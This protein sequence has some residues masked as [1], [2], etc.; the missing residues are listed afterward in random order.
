MQD[1]TT[2]CTVACTASTLQLW[3]A[4]FFGALIGWYV[5]FINRYRASEVQ[6]SDLVTLLGV[7]GGG[8]VLT[9]FP[10]RSDLFGAYGIGLFAGFFLYF[11]LLVVMVGKS[12]NFTL[13]W[14]LDGRRKKVADDEMIGP[15]TRPTMGAMLAKGPGPQ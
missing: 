3:G 9:L 6:I 14:F 15:E 12:P 5:Y 8:A 4:A 1:S 2:V 10:A 13:D 11:F 7:I